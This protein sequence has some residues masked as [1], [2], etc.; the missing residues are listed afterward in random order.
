ME[1]LSG[2]LSYD[3]SNRPPPSATLHSEL[4]QP[5]EGSLIPQE[6]SQNYTYKVSIEYA[7]G[8]EPHFTHEEKL[9]I[10][11]PTYLHGEGPQLRISTT[12]D[13]A[14]PSIRDQA[15]PPRA[16]SPMNY[17]Q[18]LYMGRSEN[19]LPGEVRSSIN[20]ELGVSLQSLRATRPDLRL[21][22]VAD[23]LGVSD[24]PH[25][26]L[27]ILALLIMTGR[28]RGFSS[29]TPRAR[30]RRHRPQNEVSMRRRS[31]CS[32]RTTTSDCVPLRST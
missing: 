6:Q 7:Q 4:A 9:D 12:A 1:T 26:P 11:Y 18:V 21:T 5:G 8:E 27:D 24:H 25:E 16:M 17:E 15:L 29:Q 10:A 14:V 28:F 2:D 20:E 13:K 31:A 32:S 23:E 3:Q 30:R 22:C 19:A